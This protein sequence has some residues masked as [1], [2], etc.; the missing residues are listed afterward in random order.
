MKIRVLR[1][2]VFCLSLASTNLAQQP[3]S[4]RLE[5]DDFFRE[6]LS[7]S[8]SAKTLY[9]NGAIEGSYRAAKKDLVRGLPVAGKVQGVDLRG[10]FVFGP[11]GPTQILI[12]YVFAAEK[13]LIRV[14][15]LT[16]VQ[17]RFIS[18][19]TGLLTPAQYQAFCDGL[20]EAKVLSPGLP[21]DA[22]SEA[23]F[24]T[25]L[26]RWSN[27]KLDSY[28]GSTVSPRPG[29][30][31]ISFGRLTGNLLRSLTRTYPVLHGPGAN[32]R[33]K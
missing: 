11:Y 21:D 13:G 16:M 4:L 9:Y 30:D 33:N 28:Y 29:A 23:R 19:T 31:V 24:E 14:N 1:T 18:K 6:A 15:Q 22:Q 3:Q 8:P 20:L 5:R 10:L 25:V 12:V 26:A 32:L 27:G 7:S 17:G 2:V